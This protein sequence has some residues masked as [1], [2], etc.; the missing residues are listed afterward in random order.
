MTEISGSEIAE[1]ANAP[2]SATGDGH[3]VT[4]HSIPDQIAADKY[5]RNSAILGSG[6]PYNAL[7]RVRTISRGA[8]D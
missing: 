5:R 6:N 4:T 8:T 1:N 7:R 3:S 2:K